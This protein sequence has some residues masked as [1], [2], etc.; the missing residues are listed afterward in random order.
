MVPELLKVGQL[1]GK[2]LETNVRER[3][4]VVISS[5]LAHT[6]SASGPYGFSNASEPFDEAIGRWISDPKKHAN[7]LLRTAKDLENRALSCGFTGLVM[8]HGMLFE[9]EDDPRPKWTTSLLANAHP[10]YYG[11]A[12]GSMIPR[13]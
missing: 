12:V 6:H 7:S 1:V 8:L 11:M 10:T 2:Y 4:L 9:G 13:R 5:D 3:V